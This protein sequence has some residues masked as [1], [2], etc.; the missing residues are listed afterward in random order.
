MSY[1]RDSE[2][3]LAWREWLRRNKNAIDKC[4]LPETILRSESHWWD[5]LMHAYLDHHED[6]SEF[7]VDNLSRSEMKYLKEF[8]ESELTDEEKKSALVLLQVE[9][10]L[11]VTVYES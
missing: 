9:A 2:K 7:S 6:L 11:N 3:E 10:K 8:L 4:G 5:F 1:R